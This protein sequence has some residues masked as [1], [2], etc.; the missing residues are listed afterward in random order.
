MNLREQRQ[1]E[2]SDKWLGSGK[3]GIILA[4]PRVGKCRIAIFSLQTYDDDPTILIAYPDNK[5]KQS[6]VDEFEIMDYD[7]SNVTYTTHLSLHKYQNIKFDVV[8][9]DE[10]HLL[11]K[12]QLLSCYELLKKNRVCLALTGT[13]AKDT[14]K[15]IYDVLGLDVIAEYS[16]EQAIKEG[17]IANYEISVVSVPLDNKLKLFN[18]KTEK[19]KFDNISWVIDKLVKEGKDTSS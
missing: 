15:T 10:I 9:I 11:S 1:L 12:K 3:F 4:A 5:I 17:V 19:Q 8:I 14:R 2:L 18:G 7:V 6:W 13:L 16:I